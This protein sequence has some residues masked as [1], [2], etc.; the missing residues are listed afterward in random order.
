MTETDSTASEVRLDIADG[1]AVMT[2]DAPDRYNALTVS[3]A[4]EMHRCFEQVD[5]DPSI[6]ALV[7]TGAGRAFCAGA[8]LAALSE[9]GQEPLSDESLA[10]LDAIYGSFTRLGSVG[11]PTIAAVNGAAVG[12]GVN[13][14][15]ATDLRLVAP[16]ARIIGGFLKR[17]L[18]PGGG[19]F[20]LLG[21]SAGR[22]AAAAVGLFG[23]EVLGADAVSKGIA[24]EAIEPEHLIERA[25]ELATPIAAD[26]KLARAM[27]ASFRTET[28]ATQM[29]WP[30][31]V[32]FERTPQLWSMHR[33]S[34]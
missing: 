15:F 9:A 14:M 18:H 26:P 25:I 2:L 10:D 11:V 21:R 4:R 7:V 1:V 30:A 19:H 13:L 8:H 16:K 5:A 20:L 34:H 31:A 32:Q 3:M 17:S 29:T 12:A 28:E 24:W 27:V 33:L 6:G 23:Q 22:D